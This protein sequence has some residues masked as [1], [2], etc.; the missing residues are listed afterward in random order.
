MTAWPLPL[1][2]TLT[3]GRTPDPYCPGCLDKWVGRI[4]VA[5][6]HPACRVALEVIQS[7]P[8]RNWDDE[9]GAA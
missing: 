6:M 5:L 1:L 2:A 4:D 8:A 3:G 9:R 7:T